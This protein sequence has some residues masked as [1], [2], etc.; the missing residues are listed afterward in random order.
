[1]A[2]EAS[3]SYR[4]STLNSSQGSWS[5]RKVSDPWLPEHDTEGLPSHSTTTSCYYQAFEL[6]FFFSQLGISLPP[7]KL[8]TGHFFLGVKWPGA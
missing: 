5:P 1:V 3:Y 7:F 2:F 8:I 6:V 4:E